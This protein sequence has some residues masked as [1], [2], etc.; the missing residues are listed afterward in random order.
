MIYVYNTHEEDHTDKGDNN[1]YIGR[2]KKGNPLSNPFTFGGKRKSLAKLSFPTREEAIA[3]FE[4]YFDA[5]YGTDE[6]LT[7]AFDKIYEKYKNGEDIYLQCFCKPNPCHG[8]V[9]A[10]KL[11]EKLI[12]EKLEARKNK[13]EN[14]QPNK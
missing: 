6:E 4:Q 12:K 11:Q 10:R 13:K 14:E 7:N 3:A 1:F 9:I 2:S 8:D 5:V